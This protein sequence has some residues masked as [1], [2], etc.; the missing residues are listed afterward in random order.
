MKYKLKAKV[1]NL[2][3]YKDIRFIKEWPNQVLV[4]RYDEAKA[5]AIEIEKSLEKLGLYEQEEKQNLAEK[6]NRTLK[7]IEF[8][9]DTGRERNILYFMP[10]EEVKGIC[11][12]IFNDKRKFKLVSKGYT[13]QA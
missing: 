2:K 4:D 1:K 10:W 8:L 3:K 9:E 12:R 13:P 6:Y 5:T 11:E 7:L